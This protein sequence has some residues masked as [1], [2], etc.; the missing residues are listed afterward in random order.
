VRASLREGQ[1]GERGTGFVLQRRLSNS[2][3]TPE[4]Q[5][6]RVASAGHKDPEGCDKP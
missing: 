3:Q 1:R 2:S 4:G 5:Q 6:E